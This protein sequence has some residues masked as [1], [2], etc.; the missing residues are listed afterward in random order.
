MWTHADK[1]WT[2][3]D[4][5]QKCGQILTKDADSTETHSMQRAMVGY[6]TVWYTSNLASKR[7]ILR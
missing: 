6:G 3:A 1:M 5:P 2:D 7:D 4:C